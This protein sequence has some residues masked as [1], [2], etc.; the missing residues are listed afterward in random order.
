LLE[1]ITPGVKYIQ[2]LLILIRNLISRGA[3]Y[4]A[5]TGTL[6]ANNLAAYNSGVMVCGQSS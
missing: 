5:Q 3:K 6:I 4:N 2:V 1:A